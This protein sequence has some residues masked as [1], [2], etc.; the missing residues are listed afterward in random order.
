MPYL[1]NLDRSE[2]SVNKL[3]CN[4]CSYLTLFGENT[5]AAMQLQRL[6]T[7]Q[8]TDYYIADSDAS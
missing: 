2:V 7:A 1:G 3:Q 8:C 5:A 6:Q 4:A